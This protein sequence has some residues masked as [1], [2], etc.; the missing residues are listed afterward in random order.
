MRASDRVQILPQLMA[1]D[2][3]ADV[4]AIV[5]RVRGTAARLALSTRKDLGEAVVIGHAKHLAEGGHEVYV[6]IDDQ[7]G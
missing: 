1:D 7:G 5:A 2:E 3:R 4:V 6:L